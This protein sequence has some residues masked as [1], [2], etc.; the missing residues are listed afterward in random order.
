MSESEAGLFTRT[1]KTTTV[2]LFGGWLKPYNV[3]Y[4]P[5]MVEETHLN[6]SFL[7]FSMVEKPFSSAILDICLL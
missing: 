2:S 7:H 1:G 6:M 3:A 4:L 5:A